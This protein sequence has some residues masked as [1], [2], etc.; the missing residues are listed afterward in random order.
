MHAHL[1]AKLPPPVAT[2]LSVLFAAGVSWRVPALQHSWFRSAS[3]AGAVAASAVLLLTW[4]TVEFRRQRT[5]ILPL[6]QP[7]RLLC[8]GPFRFSRNPIYLGMLLLTVV[9]W[10]AL[11]RVGLLLAPA[12][13]FAVIHFAVIPYEEGRL[14]EVFG[15]AYVAY[16]RRVR[17][18]L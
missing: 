8:R 17:R 9:P 4:A 14:Q 16:R 18:W 2:S 3:A 13:F 10:L 11:G 1:W 12:L 6:C 15:D 7:T 5:T